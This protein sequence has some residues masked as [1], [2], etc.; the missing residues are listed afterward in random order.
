MH[1]EKLTPAEDI[2]IKNYEEAIDFVFSN[3]DVNNVA[4]SGSYGAGKSSIMAAY[5]KKHSDKKFC[6]YPWL[7]SKVLANLM[8]KKQ[9]TIIWKER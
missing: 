6:I 7:I 5:E 4:L 3:N 8:I 9:L 1:F 2:D